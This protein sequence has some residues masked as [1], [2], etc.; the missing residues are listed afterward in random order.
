MINNALVAI[1]KVISHHRIQKININTF[2][3]I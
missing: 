1:D 3:Y 2:N